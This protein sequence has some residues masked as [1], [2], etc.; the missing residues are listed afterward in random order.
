MFQKPKIGYIFFTFLYFQLSFAQGNVPKKD[1]SE[2]YKDIQTYSKKH[3]FTT[4]IHKLFFKPINPKQK[5]A[6]KLVQQNYQ[7]FEGKIIRTIAII[8]LDPFGY[9][10]IDST[11]KPR[12]W[13]EKNG[14][15]IHIKTKKL[16]IRN[17]LL[18]KEK[19]PLDS[20]L[21]KESLRLLRA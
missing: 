20:L 13:V 16:A 8:T 2:V 18:I 6:K 1:S 17:V 10:E 12:N 4:F 3:K 14:N 15:S 7:T 21:V 9:S 5:T 19:Q 11:K